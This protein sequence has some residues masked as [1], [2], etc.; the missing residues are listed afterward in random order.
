[1]LSSAKQQ[2]GIIIFAVFHICGF[3]L[4]LKT[5]AVAYLANIVQCE[6]DRIIAKKSPLSKFYVQ[7]TFSLSLLKPW[8]VSSNDGNGNENSN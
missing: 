8:N 4:E 2:R 7:V 3:Q 6:Q 1:M 5:V